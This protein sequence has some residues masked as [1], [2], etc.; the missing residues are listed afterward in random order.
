MTRYWLQHLF[1][2][3]LLAVVQTAARTA[4]NESSTV[5]PP[6]GSFESYSTEEREFQDAIY[7]KMQRIVDWKFDDDERIST[8]TE[9]LRK[10]LD[11]EVLV[12]NKALEEVGIDAEH[13][14]PV[15]GTFS[16]VSM[17]QA[18]EHMLRQLEM[19]WTIEGRALVISTQEELESRLIVRVYDVRDLVVTGNFEHVDFDQLIEL[20]IGT[21]ACDTWAQNG[22]GNADAWPFRVDGIHALVVSQSA[23]VQR[24]IEV[25]LHDLRQLRGKNAGPWKPAVSWEELQAKLNVVGDESTADKSAAERKKLPSLI[26]G[27]P[28]FEDA[29]ARNNDFSLDLFRKAARTGS[30]QLVSGYGAREMLTLASYGASGETREQFA[31]VLRLPS[32]HRASAAE[33]LSIRSSLRSRNVGNEISINNAVWIARD[34]PLLPKY[35]KLAEVYMEAT[36]NPV[37]F[38]DVS[39]TVDAINGWAAAR[40][41]NRIKD[42]VDAEFVSGSDPCMLTNVV[43]FLGGWQT[44]F[45]RED[46]KPREFRLSSGESVQVPTMRGKFEARAGV[47]E[48]TGTT[49]GELFYGKRKSSMVILLPIDRKGGLAELEQSLTHEKLQEWLKQLEDGTVNVELPKFQFEGRYE[50]QQALAELGLRDAFNPAKADFSGITGGKL[51]LRRVRQVTYIRVDESGTEAAGFTGGGFFGGPRVVSV[52]DLI[53][54]RPFLFLIRDVRTG[55]ILFVGRV[56]DPRTVDG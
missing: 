2:A 17:Q 21:V 12:E 1:V 3:Y 26:Y 18:L 36:V 38:G 39:G 5:T 51:F 10:E 45:Q 40:T 15:R 32:T 42:A 35:Q 43:Y 46:T 33:S 47:D 49:I 25:L 16:R 55:C 50:L 14:L 6:K 7:R 9:L 48:E 29:V 20:I 24:Q 54:D 53:V 23:R 8:L 41:R 30:N 4:E 44:K 52:S 56:V 28:E 19:D 37:N 31:Q 11:C 22:G 34:L 13:D 27:S